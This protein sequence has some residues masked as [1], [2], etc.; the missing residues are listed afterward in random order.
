MYK[1]SEIFNSLPVWA[2]IF[3]NSYIQVLI[4]IYSSYIL[5]YKINY[6]DVFL[7]FESTTC[8]TLRGQIF[9]LTH[10]C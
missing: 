9:F 2:L 5:F 8:D 1:L 6:I 3:Y 7:L 4:F 10:A